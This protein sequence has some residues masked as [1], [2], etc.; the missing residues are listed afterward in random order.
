MNIRQKFCAH[1]TAPAPTAL[2][3]AERALEGAKCD[4]LEA[5]DRRE[6]YAAIEGMLIERTSRL[7]AVIE[8]LKREGA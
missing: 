6:Y 4:L 3:L 8:D 1:F 5:S 7:R 2:D